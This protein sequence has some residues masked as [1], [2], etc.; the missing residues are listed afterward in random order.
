MRLWPVKWLSITPHLNIRCLDFRSWLSLG[1]APSCARLSEACGHAKFLQSMEDSSL[2][3]G[4]HIHKLTL[5]LSPAQFPSSALFSTHFPCPSFP[6]PLLL[7]FLWT[8]I[9]PECASMASCLGSGCSLPWF[10]F[11]MS[12]YSL[13]FQSP[14]ESPLHLWRS[15]SHLK[16]CPTPPRSTASVPHRASITCPHSC[17]HHYELG[18]TLSME[19]CVSQ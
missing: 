5:S 18:F 2:L 12:T 4:K 7:C 11:C 9:I 10:P 3:T 14:A 8:H 15:H 19:E 1:P 13:L 6:R 16:T 17:L